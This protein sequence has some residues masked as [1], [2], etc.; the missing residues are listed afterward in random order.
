MQVI[1]TGATGFLGSSLVKALVN[2]GHQVIILKRSTSDTTRL[3]HFLPRIIAYDVDCIHFAEVFAK[4]GPVDA[5]IHT[6]TCY[7]RR[8]E[9]TS[10]ILTA[11]TLFPLKVLEAAAE[12]NVPLFINTDT[13]LDKQVNSDALSKKQFQEWGRQFAASGRIRFINVNLEHMYGPG[14]DESKFTTHVI[15]SCLKNVPELPLTLGEQ[16]RDFIY[17]DDVVSAYMLLLNNA[18]QGQ[19]AFLEFDVGSG[20]ALSIRE[21]VEIVH[22]LTNSRTRLCFGAVAYRR[23]EIMASNSNTDALKALGW[24][25]ATD[26]E[27]GIIACIKEE[28]KTP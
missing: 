15:N 4:H 24:K 2:S 16:K 1:V 7:G 22:R 9:S 19:G 23:N 12:H 14:D 28:V 25:S 13:V 5:V 27:N 20:Q 26:L 8:G 3:S 10:E 6:A 18:P 21:F 17:I 11:N